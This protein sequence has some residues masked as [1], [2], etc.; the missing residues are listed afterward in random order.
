MARVP[1]AD[2]L[3]R[4]ATNGGLT[5]ALMDALGDAVVR[6]Q[7]LRPQV[8]GWEAAAALLRVTAGNAESALAAGLPSEAVTAWRRQIEAAIDALRLWL[9]DRAAAGFVRR[10]HGD[11]HLGN[12][13][14]WQGTPVPFD[15][16]EF[17]EALATIDTGYDLAFLLMDLEHHV[18]RGAATRVMNRVI[19]RTGDVAMT[20]GLPVFLS[21]RAMIRAHVLAAMDEPACGLSYLDSAQRYLSPPTPGILAIGGLQGTGKSTLARVLAGRLGAAPGAV[22][23]RSDELR[24]RLFGC[25]PEERLPPEAY[26][27]DANQ[28]VNAMLIS[29]A[30]DVVAGGHTV[31]LD[32]TFLDVDMR[33]KAA[34][35]AQS[36]GVKFL[37]VWLHAPLAELERR[38]AERTNDASDATLDVLRRSAATEVPPS[39]WLRT[40]SSDIDA[41]AK[42]VL[43]N[44]DDDRTTLTRSR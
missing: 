37:G 40:G 14:L 25:A 32:A 22:V 11:L 6:D 39:D 36:A 18:G 31:I 20:R 7:A 12:L 35:A 13:C 33:E 30:R 17:D 29:Q 42:A 10:C 44:L 23:L 19:A 24:K 27:E 43:C 28:R 9:T 41:A 3:D 34:A 16:L 1:A 21:L 5:P 4:I 15:A 2:F 8:A 38:I 26:S